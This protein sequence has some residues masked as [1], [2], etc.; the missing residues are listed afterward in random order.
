MATAITPPTSSRNMTNMPKSEL[1]SSE[2]ELELRDEL[3]LVEL[4]LVE[5][6]L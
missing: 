6:E 3:E 1:V 4:E 5:L 2:D